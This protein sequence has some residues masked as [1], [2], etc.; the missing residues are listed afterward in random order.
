MPNSD[1]KMLVSGEQH[2]TKSCTKTPSFPDGKASG[3]P[4]DAWPGAEDLDCPAGRSDRFVAEDA[5]FRDCQGHLI[6][7]PWQRWL[8]DLLVE[9][10]LSVVYVYV[11]GKTMPSIMYYQ[12]MKLYWPN[13]VMQNK[14]RL[15]LPLAITLASLCWHKGNAEWVYF[16][17][18]E[19]VKD[20]LTIFTYSFCSG[21][22]EGQAITNLA[23]AQILFFSFFCNSMIWFSCPGR[24]NSAWTASSQK[25]SYLKQRIYMMRLHHFWVFMLL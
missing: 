6:K 10:L 9:E 25:C 8:K 23:S 17:G 14:E 12:K 7:R 15:P 11:L 18:L 4:P 19:E 3:A 22:R 21:Y 1:A 13:L 2:I 24:L 5:F 16:L 20:D